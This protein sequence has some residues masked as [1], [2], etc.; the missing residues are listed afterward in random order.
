MNIPPPINFKRIWVISPL[1]IFRSPNPSSSHRAQI[2]K[3][4]KIRRSTIPSTTKRI[5]I[6]MN[7]P[8]LEAR[9]RKPHHSVSHTAGSLSKSRQRSLDIKVQT[10]AQVRTSFSD[11]GDNARTYV[12]KE[13]DSSRDVQT[14]GSGEAGMEGQ[15]NIL[16]HETS[17]PN[18]MR[19]KSALRK[20]GTSISYW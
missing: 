4:K 14:M 15:E 16:S 6:Y 8:S 18:L 17:D 7:K 11:D 12:N 10:Q 2:S 5:I 20:C 9:V 3:Q 1:N 13:K 19:R